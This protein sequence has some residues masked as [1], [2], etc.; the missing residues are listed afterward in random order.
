MCFSA[1]F[2]SPLEILI[3][4]WPQRREKTVPALFPQLR[5]RLSGLR[6]IQELTVA[7]AVRLLAIARQE[8]CKSRAHVAGHVFYHHGDGIHLR[9]EY[10]KELFVPNLR[11]RALGKLLVVPKQ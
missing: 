1:N 3:R 10:S 2:N 9:I 11:H 6:W 4:Q 5:Q 8:L 7:I